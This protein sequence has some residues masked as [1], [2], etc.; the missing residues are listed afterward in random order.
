ME[1]STSSSAEHPASPSASPVSEADWTTCV[2]T[3]RS[4]FA[5]LLKGSN[6][7]GLS[8]KMSPVS[9]HRT[10]DGTL[11]PSSGRWKTSGM[12]SPTECLT[13]ST[14]EWPSDADV[15]LLS[16]TLETGV[17]PQRFFLSATACQGILRRAEK[18]GKKLPEMLQSALMSVVELEATT[19]AM[20]A[21][22]SSDQEP[23]K[24]TE[25]KPSSP[26]QEPT[27]AVR[28]LTPVECERLQ[29]FPDNF[30]AIPW[31]KKGAEDCPDGPR[32]KA[33]GNSMAVPVMRWI[34]ERIHL[35]DDLVS[36]I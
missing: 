26:P 35:V 13:L 4:S 23:I 29:G 16:D 30:T 7:A 20:S 6:L 8:G 32:Y 24:D 21:A 34:G 19:K 11:V 33:L 15:C 2:V 28:R 5:D 27:S 25:V 31:R 1:K 17:L 36:L 14:S 3:L 12:A 10:E 18:R 22:P 9:C